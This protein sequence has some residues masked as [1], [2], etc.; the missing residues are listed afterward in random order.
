M[1]RSITDDFDKSSR[2]E[3]LEVN[4]LGGYA[5]GTV[6]GPLTRR[7]HGLLIAALEP[8]V[9]RTVVLSKLDETIVIND[10]S[11]QPAQRFELG[12]NQFPNAVHPAG[13]HYMCQF[14]RD[15][16][17]VFYYEA[18][19][20][21]LKKTIAALLDENTTLVLYE[22][23]DASA[24]FTMELLPLASCRDH[25]SISSE[26]N[27]IGRQ[28]LFEDGLF[29]TVN[30]HGGPEVFIYVPGSTF[31]EAQGWYRN[32]EYLRELERGL[33]FRED[34]YTHG[35]FKVNLRK[36]STLGVIISTGDTSQKNAFDLFAVEQQRR[37]GLRQSSNSSNPWWSRLML[38]ADQFIARR[39]K[40]FTIIAGYHWFTDWGRDTMI[41]LPGLCLATGRLSIARDIL[42]QYARFV[43]EGMLPNRFPD[44]GEQPEYNTMDATL[45]FFHAAYQ[46]FLATDDIVLIE[47]LLPVFTSIVASHLRGTRYGIGVD[48]VD[49]LLRG[50]QPG[51]QLTWMDAKVGDWVVTPR[52]GKPVEINAL[53]YNALRVMETIHQRL[54]NQ[55]EAGAFGH[56]A[57]KVRSNFQMLF[58]N[59]AENC[60][61][62]YLDS[63]PHGE[64]RP[65]Q[66]YAVSLPFPLFEGN[67]ARAIVDVVKTKL[68]TPV[69]LRSLAQNSPGYIGRCVGPP[70]ERDAAYH[71]GTVWTFLIGAFI[72]ALYAVEGNAAQKEASAIVNNCCAHLDDACVGS[73]SEVFDGDWPHI[74]RG[75]VAQ[76]WSVAELVRVIRKYSL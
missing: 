33:E 51:T 4:G 21:R 38:A 73:I 59:T 14:E 3:W 15:V 49:E 55:E 31:V 17:P 27:A 28:Y 10:N 6:S 20:V 30:Y 32:F 18:G 69:G 61:F 68:L 1:D 26:N 41:S 39:G 72:D 34:L 60:L 47:K 53:W 35:H 36:G 48:P 57:D 29:R 46:Y 71:Q 76:A 8:P 54:G 7:Y 70:L 52:V 63:S 24:E 62:D 12:T 13:Y 11:T 58:W 75:C 16:F 40:S 45:W 64:I 25:H 44:H 74:A 50:G 5:S 19:N 37:E 22:V 42:L 67:K 43:S 23:L 2:L 66:I 9:K 56:R 65:N